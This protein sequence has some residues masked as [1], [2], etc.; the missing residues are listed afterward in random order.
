MKFLLVN[1]LS[2]CFSLLLSA[3]SFAQDCIPAKPTQYP[4]YVHDQVGALSPDQLQSLEMNLKRF[5]DSTSNQFVIVIVGDLCGVTAS[6][7]GTELGQRWGVGAAKKDNG[8]VI[9]IKTTE[10]DGGR[11]VAIEVGRG[12]EPVITDGTAKL[13]EKNE[14]IPEFKKGNIYQ[15][16]VNSL[17]VLMPLAK[18]EFNEAAYRER[19]SG[20]SIGMIFLIVLAA[21][22][23]IGFK[24]VQARSYAQTNH[25]SFWTA[26]MLMSFMNRGRGSWNDF[27]S[28]RGGFG[29]G[30]GGGFGGFGG[31]SFGGGGAESG[32]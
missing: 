7:Y 20:G 22:F 31:G 8:L 26:L 28:G 16:L 17:N 13:I 9:V 23:I 6:E 10:G 29:G 1:T 32:W 19:S 30:S 11:K 2:I 18:K 3:T 5:D 14:M 4:F 12:L 27:S 24:S 15:G 21:I 25:T